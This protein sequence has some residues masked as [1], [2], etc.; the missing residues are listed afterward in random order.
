MQTVV[1][2]RVDDMDAL[3]RGA[4]HLAVPIP[5]QFLRSLQSLPREGRGPHP[6]VVALPADEA[7]DGAAETGERRLHRRGAGHVPSPV[8][9]VRIIQCEPG[10]DPV[11]ILQA[12]QLAR[13]PFGQL[14]VIIPDRL[15]KRRERPFHAFLAVHDPVKMGA[16][17]F[18]AGEDGVA[19]GREAFG[20][21]P[22][23]RVGRNPGQLDFLILRNVLEGGACIHMPLR[24][25]RI[26]QNMFAGREIALVIL[27]DLDQ[28]RS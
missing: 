7:A 3:L 19:R 28:G 13:L 1:A 14:L 11:A 24:F 23:V 10:T 25:A 17:G 6:I 21:L 18:L 26:V 4:I 8:H 12:P 15:A 22:P 27:K 20:L 5:L 9:R 2:I 16:I